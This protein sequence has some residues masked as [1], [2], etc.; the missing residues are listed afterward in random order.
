MWSRKKLF[1]VRYSADLI[2]STGNLPMG[3][4][5][6]SNY[7]TLA[8]EKRLKTIDKIKTILTQGG[9]SLFRVYF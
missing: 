1:F 4:Y 7:V 6:I 5:I 8:E 9:V 2:I 3:R